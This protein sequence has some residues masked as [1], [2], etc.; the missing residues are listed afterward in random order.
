MLE[1]FISYIVLL[2]EINIILYANVN[3]L[4]RFGDCLR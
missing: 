1:Q 3:Q 4:K 2:I